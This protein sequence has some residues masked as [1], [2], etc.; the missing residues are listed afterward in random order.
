MTKFED[1]MCDPTRHF[2]RPSQVLDQSDWS[3]EEQILLL[4]QWAYDIKQQSRA[5]E[6]NM[7]SND[8][9]EN[10]LQEINKLLSKLGGT[11]MFSRDRIDNTDSS[12]GN[13]QGA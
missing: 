3:R 8:G 6:E 13:A 9:E 1:A 10:A 2:E 7:G 12:L 4:R 11:K 5:S